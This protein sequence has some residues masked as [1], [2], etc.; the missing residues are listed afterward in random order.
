MDHLTT[1]LAE[2]RKRM[3]LEKLDELQRH[4]DQTLQ[5]LID[6]VHQNT[7]LPDQHPVQLELPLEWKAHVTPELTYEVSEPCTSQT[8][9]L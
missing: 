5:R 6:E 1:Q 8:P 4:F 3:L 7:P 9:F 2:G